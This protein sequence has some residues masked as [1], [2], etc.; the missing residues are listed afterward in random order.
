M[1]V[2]PTGF[3]LARFGQ[4]G[5]GPFT[6]VVHDGL[7]VGLAELTGEPETVDDLLADWAALRDTV[8]D[9]VRSG[10][11]HERG[12]PV[13]G[14]SPQAPFRP[15][16]VFQSGANHHTH[17]EQLALA[18]AV[19]D[20]VEDL[21]AVRTAAAERM[22][23]Q[24]E[25][26]TPYVFTGLPSAVC[27]PEDD[28]VLPPTGSWHD[29]ELEFGVV[30]GAPAHRVDRAGAMDAVAGYVIVNDLTTRDRVYRPDMATL[31]TDWLAAKNAPTFLPLGPLLVPALFI[32]DPM[33]LRLT[34]EVHGEVMQDATTA[35][36]IFDVARLIEHTSSIARLGPGDLL[37]TG[38][39]AGNGA[40]HGRCL[41]EGDVMTASATSLGTQRNRCTTS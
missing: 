17:V 7:A 21:V 19:E 24:T 41:R 16:Q 2:H 27:G 32:E 18:K 36:M 22:R 9:V 26:G 29:W 34:L 4:A 38:S 10:R 28:V 40:H 5:S 15:R 3:A 20:G 35:D 33:D 23:C 8:D 31:R 25:S 11:W 37:A 12:V 14:L 39:P 30:L 13:D 6:A 1:T